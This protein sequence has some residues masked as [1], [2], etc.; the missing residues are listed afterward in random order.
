MKSHPEI[1]ELN[2]SRLNRDGDLRVCFGHKFPR[3]D[4]IQYFHSDLLN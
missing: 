2:P 1:N 3:N 4:K